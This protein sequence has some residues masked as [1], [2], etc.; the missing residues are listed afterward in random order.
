MTD[1]MYVMSKLVDNHGKIL[2]PEIYNDVAALTDEERA[3]Y[4]CIDYDIVSG[5]ECS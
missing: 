5:C 3:L 2:I 4:E 1:L